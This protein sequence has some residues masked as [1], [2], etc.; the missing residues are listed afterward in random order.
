MT[1]RIWTLINQWWKQGRGENYKNRIELIDRHKKPFQWENQ[2]LDNENF[3]AVLDS[4]DEV[5]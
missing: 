5:I 2:E 3:Y 1:D 4:D